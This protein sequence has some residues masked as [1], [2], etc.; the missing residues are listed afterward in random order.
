[1]NQTLTWTCLVFFAL[2]TATTA[3]AQ[4][5][6][7]PLDRGIHKR[8]LLKGYSV[9]RG[10]HPPNN[11]NAKDI[12]GANAPGLR[13]P[14]QGRGTLQN[15]MPRA[16]QPVAATI[17]ARHLLRPSILPVFQRPQ[18]KMLRVL[19]MRR[20]ALAPWRSG[21][22]RDSVQ[23]NG[24]GIAPTLEEHA[25]SAPTQDWIGPGMTV[26]GL[27]VGLRAMLRGQRIGDWLA[28]VGDQVSEGLILG[29]VIAVLGAIF[30]G[31][32]NVFPVVKKVQNSAPATQGMSM[33]E[34]GIRNRN[35]QKDTRAELL[36]K[37]PTWKLCMYV[38]GLT[39]GLIWMSEL[40]AF[41]LFLLILAVI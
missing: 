30:I 37:V 1:M 4:R 20:P 29:G 19:S 40:F 21:L 41:M 26:A 32:R 17:H 24:Q 3:T 9:L 31:I 5:S 39:I 12:E 8:T 23:T 16:C 6:D 15:L 34:R 22:R 36:S 33:R 28:P 13:L 2:L 14:G 35:I 10:Q 18:P 11:K 27:L 38:F 7:K 25:A